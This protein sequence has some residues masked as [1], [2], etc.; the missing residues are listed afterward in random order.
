MVKYSADAK[1]ESKTFKKFSTVNPLQV[2]HPQT[3]N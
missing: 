2:F 1:K 3:K